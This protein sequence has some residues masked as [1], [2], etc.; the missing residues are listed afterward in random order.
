MACRFRV[1]RN[2]VERKPRSTVKISPL[3]P[4]IRRYRRE[5]VKIGPFLLGRGNRKIFSSSAALSFF[6]L[7]GQIIVVTRLIISE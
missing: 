6:W 4:E 2:D 3:W 5:R 7:Q 1:G